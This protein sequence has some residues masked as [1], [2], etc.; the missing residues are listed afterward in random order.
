MVDCAELEGLRDL[1]VSFSVLL[2]GWFLFQDNLWK[3]DSVLFGAR[4]WWHDIIIL[5]VYPINRQSINI[6][7][8]VSLKIGLDRTIYLRP[9]HRSQFRLLLQLHVKPLHFQLVQLVTHIRAAIPYVYWTIII[10]LFV[11][12]RRILHTHV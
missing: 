9:L 8:T 2:N 6:A 11:D 1:L 12:S 4:G 10:H 5:F 7:L 3:Q